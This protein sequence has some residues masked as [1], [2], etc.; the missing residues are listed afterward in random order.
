M[1]AQAHAHIT[2]R[3][4]LCSAARSPGRMSDPSKTKRPKTARH[5]TDDKVAPAT[6]QQAP[7]QRVR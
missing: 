1:E 5:M 4:H 3:P 2:T 6:K 7:P